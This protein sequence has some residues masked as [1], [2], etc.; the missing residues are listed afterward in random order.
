MLPLDVRLDFSACG[1]L[2][3]SVFNPLIVSALRGSLLDGSH[4]FPPQSIVELRLSDC[5]A[6]TP[7]LLIRLADA[8]ILRRLQV[9]ADS[10]KLDL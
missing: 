1:T 10:S 7:A 8:G 6:L 4:C 2:K 3:D 9:S 5:C